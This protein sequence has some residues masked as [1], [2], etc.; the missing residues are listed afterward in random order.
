MKSPKTPKPAST[1]LLVKY[2]NE[3]KNILL[4][5]LKAFM[6]SNPFF[7]IKNQAAAQSTLSLAWSQMFK[8]TLEKK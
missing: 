5:D 3:L 2:D 8:E 6:D 4:N 7:T 1:K